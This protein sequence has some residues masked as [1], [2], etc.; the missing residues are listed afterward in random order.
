MPECVLLL[1]PL[2]RFLN[3]FAVI[4]GPL[5]SKYVMTFFNGLSLSFNNNWDR[6]PQVLAN[7]WN[8]STAFDAPHTFG[9]ICAFQS[10][11]VAS[12]AKK[13]IFYFPQ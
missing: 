6:R 12:G 11:S 7:C 5:V 13:N 2:V 8:M 1:A 10:G 4:V 3:G 9:R